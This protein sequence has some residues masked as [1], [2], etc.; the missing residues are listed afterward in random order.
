MAEFSSISFATS[1]NKTIRGEFSVNGNRGGFTKIHAE[2]SSS[3]SIPN[4]SE[5]AMKLQNICRT[6]K[7]C[8]AVY[9]V[10]KNG[11]I[12]IHSV[13]KIDK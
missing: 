1:A 7:E 6:N 9:S 11:K 5:D 2:N 10:G 12:K 8:E 4:M 3:I 13:R